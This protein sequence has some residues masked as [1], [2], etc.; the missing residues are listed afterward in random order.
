MPKLL[1]PIPREFR[2]YLKAENSNLSASTRTAY[3]TVISKL[4]RAHRHSIEMGAVK[5]HHINLWAEQAGYPFPAA[6]RRFCAFWLAKTGKALPEPQKYQKKT[7]ATSSLGIDVQTALKEEEET[8]PFLSAKFIAEN[9]GLE[10][11]LAMTWKDFVFRESFVE[12]K[13]KKFGGDA[14]AHFVTLRNWANNFPEGPLFPVERGGFEPMKTS[15]FYAKVRKQTQ[16]RWEQVNSVF[17]K[18][19]PTLPKRAQREFLEGLQAQFP[20]LFKEKKKGADS[21]TPSSKDLQAKLF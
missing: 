5:Q 13:D 15:T 1:E 9:F 17:V 3:T 12:H 19:F 20:K 10:R 2:D 21:S 18:V 6:W 7:Q 14:F 16:E 8:W 4:W 11:S